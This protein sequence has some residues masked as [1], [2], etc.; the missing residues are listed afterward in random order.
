MPIQAGGAEAVV[1]GNAPSVADIDR[2][3]PYARRLSLDYS[4]YNSGIMIT[5]R[6]ASVS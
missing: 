5:P 6:H 1:V 2:A 3:R 4:S